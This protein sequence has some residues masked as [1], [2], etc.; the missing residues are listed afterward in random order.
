MKRKTNIWIGAILLLLTIFF[1]KV[2]FSKSNDKK[3]DSKEKVQKKV[4]AFVVKPSL[5]ISE[6][7]VNGS[8]LA[9]DEVELKNEVA[10]RVVKIN[11]PEGKFVRKGTLLV[12]LYD[13]DLQATLKK[14]QSQLAIQERIYKRQT[15]LLKV[16]GI[17]QNDYEQTL[18]QVNTIKANIA[19]EKAL[20]RKTQVQAPFDGIIGLRNI[21]VGAIV[22]PSTLLATIRTSNKLKLDFYVPE[23]Y[24][25]EIATGMKVNFTM[26]NENKLYGATV[27]ATERG[28]DNTT[29]N[30]K[31]RALINASSKELI[32]GAFANVQ[33]KLGDN[34]HALMVPSQAI[35][36]QEGDKSV[37]VAKKG[38]AHFVTIKTGIRKASKVEVTEGLQPGDTIITSG[39][40]FLKE[41]SKLSY[42]TITE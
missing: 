13:D 32:P 30:L 19:E 11:L 16:S 5:L 28:I 22:S 8:L 15:E 33:L 29:R 34:P 2:G 35:I 4:D 38:K 17:S 18:L 37:I 1:L 21:S 36:P 41:K 9:Y 27:I 20:I 6:I 42:S 3:K 10:G 23:K 7:T 40:L 26:Y 25:S 14:L 12:K 31:V 24:G 39:I